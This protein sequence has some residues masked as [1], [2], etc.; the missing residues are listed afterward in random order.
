VTLQRFNDFRFGALDAQRLNAMVDSLMRLEQRVMQLAQPYEPTKD[1]ILAQ[2]TGAGTKA[3]YDLCQ[4]AM[5][6]VSYPF[7]EVGLGI[8]QA[9]PI[10][11]QT[12]V[13]PYPIDGGLSSTR[14][15]FLI[16]IERD[17]SLNPGDVVKAHL[18]SR[19]DVATAAD[20]G[21]VYIGTPIVP[22]NAGNVEIATV[23]AGGNG[24]YDCLL[25]ESNE[26][27]QAYN[28]YETN[29]YYGALDASVECAVLSVSQTIPAG[30]TIWVFRP[31]VNGA[32]ASTWVTMTPVPFDSA[33]TCNPGNIQQQVLAAEEDA[34]KNDGREGIAAHILSRLNRI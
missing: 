34:G 24:L 25:V 27:I 19:A 13:Q 17:P 26:P 11:G 1:I 28:L 18:A 8:Q 32:P 14:G 6:A 5:R 2:V 4:G 9:G 21:M 31:L 33:C 29:N 15:A 3:A 7:Q 22:L 12:C 16:L 23:V 10:S 30:S 20:K